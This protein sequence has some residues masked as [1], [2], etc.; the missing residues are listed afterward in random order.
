MS[1]IKLCIIP[2]EVMEFILIKQGEI[3][4]QKKIGAYSQ[5]KCVYQLLKEHP[6]FP[7]EKKIKK[8]HV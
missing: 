2:E 1:Y 3:K 8:E 6:D 4:S 5:E 7:K